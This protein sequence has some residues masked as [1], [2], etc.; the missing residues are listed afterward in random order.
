MVPLR[1][2]VW[3]VAWMNDLLGPTDRAQASVRT[4]PCRRNLSRPGPFA[5]V[6][7]VSCRRT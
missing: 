5:G 4:M 2:L 3:N 1:L 7:I 6:L